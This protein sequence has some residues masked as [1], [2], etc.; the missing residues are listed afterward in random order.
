MEGTNTCKIGYTNEN[1]GPKGRMKELQTG[2]PFKLSILGSFLSEYGQKIEGIMHRQHS[3]KKID[4]ELNEL[5][6]EWFDLNDIDINNFEKD[7]K[8]TEDTILFL[9]ETSTLDNPLRYL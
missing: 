1:K 3:D 6:G 2:C 8:G 4:E 5:Q 7:C 9:L